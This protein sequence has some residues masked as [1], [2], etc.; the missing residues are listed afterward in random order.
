MGS[1]LRRRRAV[2][3][4]KSRH[5]GRGGPNPVQRAGRATGGGRGLGSRWGGASLGRRWRGPLS[6]DPR[7]GTVDSP[8]GHVGHLRDHQA[9]SCA[10]GLPISWSF[11]T[12]RSL[13]WEL[14][15][16]SPAPPSDSRAVSAGLLLPQESPF[17]G[18]PPVPA[19]P[20]P[21]MQACSFTHAQTTAQHG[22]FQPL[23]P[24]PAWQPLRTS[25]WVRR[26]QGPTALSGG[27]PR[28]PWRVL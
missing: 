19:A 25:S 18:A 1:R 11:W 2:R 5:L 20:T 17:P 16:P 28:W 22:G 26:Q 4:G 6:P 14:A 10:L 8:V 7:G 23:L 3:R 12:F 24:D 15:L 13:L 9:H 27:A 21:H